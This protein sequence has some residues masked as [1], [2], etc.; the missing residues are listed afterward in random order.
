MLQESVETGFVVPG[1]LSQ[2]LHAL[3]GEIDNLTLQTATSRL[4]CYLLKKFPAQGCVLDFEVRKTVIAS[5]ISVTPETFSRIVN[6]LKELNIIDAKSNEV[7]VLN[8]EAL[9]KLAKLDGSLELSPT[10]YLPSTRPTP[11]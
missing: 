6:R 8:R 1:A 9:Q 10:P 5:R 4:A 3:I 2:R 7:T 11:D